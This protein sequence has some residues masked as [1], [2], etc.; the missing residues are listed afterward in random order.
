M[1]RCDALDAAT[2]GTEMRKPLA[3]KRAFESMGQSD[4]MCHTPRRTKDWPDWAAIAYQRGFEN[5]RWSSAMSAVKTW[6]AAKV[7]EAAKE[8]Q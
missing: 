1:A 6:P 7:F 2:G 3:G 8:P 4:F 5:A